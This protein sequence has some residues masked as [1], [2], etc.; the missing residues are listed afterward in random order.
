MEAQDRTAAFM[1]RSTPLLFL[2]ALLATTA[3][4]AL[5]HRLTRR[6]HK[7]RLRRLAAEWGMQYVQLD[8][9]DLPRRIAGSFP[10]PGAADLHVLD[11][12]YAT[13]GQRHRYVFTAEYT[14]GVTDQHH[15][16]ARAMTFCEPVEGATPSNRSPLVAAPDY[17]TLP[18]QYEY[19]R[20]EWDCTPA[21][22]SVAAPA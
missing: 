16:I 8:L 9:F 3:L 10:V 14:T 7:R 21:S 6:R 1:L 2:F 4:A 18:E 5:I 11:V 20:R 12:I 17:L 22:S 19:L 15:R 13:H